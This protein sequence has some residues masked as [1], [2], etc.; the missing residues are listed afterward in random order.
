[1]NEREEA[2]VGRKVNLTVTDVEYGK[3]ENKKIYKRYEVVDPEFEKEV[4]AIS[5]ENR[6]FPPGTAGTMDFKSDRLNVYINKD[7]I[8]EMVNYG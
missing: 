5:S 2:L 6:I 8:V 7:G 4:K 1:M 3:D